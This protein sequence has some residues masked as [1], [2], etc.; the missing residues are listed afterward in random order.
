M[1][2]TTF[3]FFAFV[4]TSSLAFSQTYMYYDSASFYIENVKNKLPLAD[5]AQLADAD[6]GELFARRSKN[7]SLLTMAWYIKGVLY[8]YL[9]YYEASNSF[10]QMALNKPV[11]Q[12]YP[13]INFRLLN[14]TGINYDMLGKAKESLLY[15]HRALDIVKSL[16]NEKG[17]AQVKINIG[18]LYRVSRDYDKSESYLREALDYFKTTQDTFYLGLTYQNLASLYTDMDKGEQDVIN[19]FQSALNNY[20]SISYNYG[21]V[22]LYHNL[23]DYYQTVMGDMRKAVHCFNKALDISDV[24]NMHQNSVPLI[25]A[26]GKIALIAQDYLQ[27]ENYANRAYELS[28]QNNMLSWQQSALKLL[29]KISIESGH[30]NQA[31]HFFQEYISF[32]DST[33]SIDKAKSYNELSVLY[34]IKQKNEH[35]R[36]QQLEITNHKTHEKWLITSLAFVIFLVMALLF[37][38]RFRTKK[39]KQQYQLNRE[40]YEQENIQRT[41]SVILNNKINS[42]IVSHGQK[43]LFDEIQ[44]LIRTEKLFLDINLSVSELA[45]RLN[46]NQKYISQAINEH[47]GMN[48]PHF[49]N[50]QRVQE[51]RRLIE[52]NGRLGYS[53]EQ[54]MNRSGFRSRTTFTESFKCFTGMTPGQ[55]QRFAHTKKS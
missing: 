35:L 37:F 55:Y 25:L 9:S 32:S 3:L 49:L 15:Y 26:L 23:G 8:Y 38:I 39:L 16:K 2:I 29:T 12:Q 13:D 31:M 1:K 27:A 43:Q 44:D 54:I 18:R 20:Q 45:E 6:K 48:F 11:T 52:E 21:V 10:Y 33:F 42:P 4:L 30:K 34:E 19:A 47:A 53:L 51:A 50:K 40:L 24:N 17:I 46:T 14:N 5:S 22:E 36:N 28:K 7:D 41:E